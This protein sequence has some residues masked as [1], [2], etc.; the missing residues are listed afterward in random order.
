MKYSGVDG[1]T[2]VLVK[3]G[4]YVSGTCGDVAVVV[5]IWC[6]KIVLARNS[7]RSYLFFDP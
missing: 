2:M 3:D 4:D 7:G 6:G 1:G 5:Y